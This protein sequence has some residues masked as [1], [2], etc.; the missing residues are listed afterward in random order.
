M[1]R[2]SEIFAESQ[3]LLTSSDS[4]YVRNNL[5]DADLREAAQM[6]GKG[7]FSNGGNNF[8][9]IKRVFLD[10]E[11]EQKFTEYFL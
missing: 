2:N 7:A 8:C 5:T 11:I 10:K 1:A 9:S 4:A 6:I 3:F